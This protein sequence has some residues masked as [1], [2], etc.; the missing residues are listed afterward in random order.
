MGGEQPLVERDMRTLIQR[1]GL[2][3]E[4]VA[5]GVAVIP[6]WPHGLAA[7]L[8]DLADDPA[9]RAEHTVRPARSLYG[10]A[11]LFF[12]GKSGVAEIEFGHFWPPEIEFYP[13]FMVQSS[14]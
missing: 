6:P 13:T 4:F 14:A 7:E 2:D 10:L 9:V 11:G 8:A 3:R 12:I 1:P 5:T